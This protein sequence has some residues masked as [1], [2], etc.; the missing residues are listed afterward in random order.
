MIQQNVVFIH[1]AIHNSV[2]MDTTSSMDTTLTLFRRCVNLNIYLPFYKT[3]VI[4]V[5]ILVYQPLFISFSYT[6]K[7]VFNRVI[8]RRF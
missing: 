5:E 3:K 2:S 6:K 8:T 7:Q 4:K 1:V